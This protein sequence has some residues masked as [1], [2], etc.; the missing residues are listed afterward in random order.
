MLNIG[1]DGR[2]P[3]TFLIMWKGMKRNVCVWGGAL[4]DT[5][6]FFPVKVS[7]PILILS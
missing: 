2:D 6:N 7:R 1:S 5:S 3:A 4:V